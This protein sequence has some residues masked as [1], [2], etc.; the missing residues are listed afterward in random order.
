[1]LFVEFVE[2]VERRI[3]LKNIFE[4]KYIYLLS[5]IFLLPLQYLINTK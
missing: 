5:H 1:M 4:N 2:D 3:Y